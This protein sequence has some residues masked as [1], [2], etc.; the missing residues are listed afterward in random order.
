MKRQLVPEVLQ[1]VA[2]DDYQVVAFFN[3]GSVHA[4][5]VTPLLSGAVFA[6]LRDK[7][8]FRRALTVMNHTVA[9]D[10]SGTRDATACIDIDPVVVHRAPVFP[11]DI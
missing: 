5:D 7:E 1:A 2:G 11:S 10:L 9:W 8:V 6:P 3:D 4:F